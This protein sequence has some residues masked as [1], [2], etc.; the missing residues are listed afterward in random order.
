MV[1]WLLLLTLEPLNADFA[2]AVNAGDGMTLD[3]G[4]G[5]VVCG[6]ATLFTG[7]SS[8]HVQH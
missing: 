3:M 7:G 5:T 6:E 1:F 4:K 2:A 8:A